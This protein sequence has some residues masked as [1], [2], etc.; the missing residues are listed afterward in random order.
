MKTVV[1]SK[2]C[3]PLYICRQSKTSEFTIEDFI[4]MVLED[5]D[6]VVKRVFLEVE[7]GVIIEGD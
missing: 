4:G 7:G 1:I 3:I 5:K 6:F 2:D